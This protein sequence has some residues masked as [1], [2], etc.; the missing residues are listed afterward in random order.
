MRQ[1]QAEAEAGTSSDD[2]KKAPINKTG[3]NDILNLP[4]FLYI[5]T[6]SHELF[7]STSKIGHLA[8]LCNVWCL[9]YDGSNTF[10]VS[11]DQYLVSSV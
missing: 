10:L 2:S 11:G 7:A 5:Y 4:N 1:L 8:T 6:N 9:V 3:N